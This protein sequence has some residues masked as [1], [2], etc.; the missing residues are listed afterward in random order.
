MSLHFDE[1]TLLSGF[2]SVKGERLTAVITGL[3]ERL[4]SVPTLRRGDLTKHLRTLK[5]S[6]QMFEC[7]RPLCDLLSVNVV[8]NNTRHSNLS[9]PLQICLNMKHK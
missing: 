8:G 9:S 2:D 1:Q 3:P 6:G 5:R 7:P 4:T